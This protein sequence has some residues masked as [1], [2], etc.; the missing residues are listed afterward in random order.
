MKKV[1]L[2]VSA[3]IAV[4][5]IAPWLLWWSSLPNE[6]ATHWNLSGDANGHMSRLG[7]LLVL[8]GVSVVLSLG[9]ALQPR[10]VSS[11][12]LAFVGCVIA[13]ASFATAWSNRDVTSWSQAHLAIGWVVGGLVLGL[14]AAWMYTRSGVSSPPLP[15]A[16]SRPTLA[17]SESERI[18]WI[19]STSS[20]LFQGLAFGLAVFGAIALF[21]LPSPGGV[22]TLLAALLVADVASTNVLLTRDGVRVSGAFSWPRVKID[23]ERISGADA[24]DV[25]PMQ[26]GGWGY[27]GSLTFMRRAAW[28]THAGRGLHLVLRDGKQFVVTID[29]ADEAAAVVNGLLTS[30]PR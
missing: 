30:T 1:P 14:G 18:A 17:L 25:H 28:I 9:A 5:A 11:P 12:V 7:A 22:I 23:I 10:A 21:T 6:V 16:A 2:L 27:R 20:R 24:I 29:D 19:G 4:L 15:V 26:W 3:V 13:S 8:G